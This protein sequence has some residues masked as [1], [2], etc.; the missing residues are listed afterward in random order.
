MVHHLLRSEVEVL[1]IRQATAAR[2]LLWRLHRAMNGLFEGLRYRYLGL[3]DWSLRHRT[4][5]LIG[6]RGGIARL[7]AAGAAGRARLLPRRRRRHAATPCADAAGHPH[8]A[9]RG[10]LCRSGA[11]DPRRAARRRDR[12]DSR[13]HRHSERLE[14]PR[15]GRRAEH[16]RDRRRDLDFAQS[17]AARLGARLRS[18]AAQAARRKVPRHGV[19][20]RAGQHHESDSQFRPARADR[21]A[22]GRHQRREQLQGR[23]AASAI[24]S[25]RPGRRPTCTS[26]RCSSSRS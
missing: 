23:A 16:R 5:V 25:P 1:P 20:L 14:Q 9:D 18:P 4:P 22:G 6:V 19:L 2:G 24:A 3:L 26:T 10:S 13:Q 11:G 7:G 12:H 15:A 21:P 8:R 17:R